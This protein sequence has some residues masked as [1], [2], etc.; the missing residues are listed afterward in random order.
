MHIKFL[1][2]KMGVF[3]SI[4]PRKKTDL[5]GEF[6]ATECQV[7]AVSKGHKPLTKHNQQEEFLLVQKFVGKD[8]GY[9]I[10]KSKAGNNFKNL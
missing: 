2:D 9:K 10:S 5:S 1:E 4:R 3:V 8:L 6:A 7:K